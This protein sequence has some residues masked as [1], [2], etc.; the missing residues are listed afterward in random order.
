MRPMLA[1]R[2]THVPDRRGLVARGQVGRRPDP[3]R[4][5]TRAAAVATRL[6]SRNEND[7]TVAWPELNRSPLGDRD[8]LVDGEVIALNDRRAARLRG[9]AGPDARPQRDRRGRGSPSGCPATLH[10]LRPAPPRRPDLTARAAGGAPRAARGARAR[11]RRRG[12]SRRRTTTARC[13]FDAT[14]QQ[15]LEGIVSKRLSSRYDLRRAQPALAEVRAPAPRSY[16]VGGWRPQEGTSDRLG[17]LLVGEPTRD[18]LRLPRP[19][20]QRHRRRGQPAA[21]RAARAARRGRQPVRRRGAAASTRAGTRWVE[22]RLVVDVE[23][24]GRRRAAAPPAV[25]PWR[26]HRPRPRRPERR[27][28]RDAT[29]ARR[30]C[31]LAAAAGPPRR[32]RPPARD[33]RWSL[34]GVRVA[35]RPGH[36]AGGHRQPHRRLPRPGDALAHADAGVGGTVRGP[37]TAGSGTAAWSPA[38]SRQQGTGTTPLGTYRLLS[39]FGTHARRD[40][41]GAALPPRSARGDY[42]VQ[43]NASALLQPLPQQGARAASAGGCRRATRTRSERLTDYRRQYESSSSPASTSSRSGTAA[44]GI[45]LHVNGRGATAG[46]VCAPRRFIAADDAPRPGRARR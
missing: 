25:V 16:V 42:W 18:G 26:P 20:R 43:D 34:D 23:T 37:T 38:T 19:G 6:L 10:G 9:P 3:R 4:R 40:A 22:P 12:R 35:A 44:S 14:L 41:W 11:A 46:C 30:R 15:G 17:A 31:L 13:C 8:L 5:A 1:T 33:P 7:V 27:T 21:H 24:H 2:R 39:A 28:W 29:G 45:F 36:H 32:P